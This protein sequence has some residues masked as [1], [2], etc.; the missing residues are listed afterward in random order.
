MRHVVDNK[1]C[2]ALG[3]SDG[4]TRALHDHKNL[5]WSFDNGQSA[6][7]FGDLNNRD[8][9]DILHWLKSDPKRQAMVFTGWSEHH[10]TDSHQTAHPI[11]RISVRDG[12]SVPHKHSHKNR[13]NES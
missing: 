7:G 9:D 5:W 2:A 13:V 8:L 4:M 3:L 10:G 1:L 12:I 11:G 6:F